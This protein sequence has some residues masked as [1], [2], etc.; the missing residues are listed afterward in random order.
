MY[1]PLGSPW[2]VTGHY[3]CLCLLALICLMPIWV[4]LAT[5]LKDE[6]TSS[7]SIAILVTTCQSGPPATRLDRNPTRSQICSSLSLS[8]SQSSLSRSTTTT[9]RYPGGIQFA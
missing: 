1:E 3:L 9:M 6:I 7:S 2:R 5:S 8:S 4:M